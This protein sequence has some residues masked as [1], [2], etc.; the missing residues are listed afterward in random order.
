[1]HIVLLTNEYP[2]YVY[3]GAGVHLSHLAPALARAGEGR[4]TVEV[5]SFGDQD[6]A[7][8]MLTVQGVAAP[9]SIPASTPQHGKLFDTLGRNLVM[10]GRVGRAD[11]VHAHTWY[12]HFGGVLV[13]QLTGARLVL[14][15]HSLEPHRPW[16]VEQLGTAYNASTWIERHT[17]ASADGVIAVAEAMKRDVLA[18]YD[19]DPARVAVIPNGV[20]PEEFRP[21]PDPDRARAL[22]VDPSVPS[23]LF[24]GRVTRQKGLA[25]LLR[26]VPHLP[27]GTQVIVAA[28]QA[29]TPE[30]ASEAAALV[31]ASEAA[32]HHVV[33]IEGMLPR[34]DLAVLYSHASVFC[35]PSVYEP[36]G[37]INLEAM[38]CARPVVAAAVGGVPEVVVDGE[39]GLLVPLDPISDTNP[40]PSNPDAFARDLAEAITRVLARPDEARR[41]GQ[42]GRTRVEEHFSWDIIARRTLAFYEKVRGQKPEVREEG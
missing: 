7:D 20:D 40:D 12:A 28:G 2:P 24:V 17:Y 38:A 41:M 22:G 32:G 34:K 25:H 10:A 30:L 26:A 6:L 8:G 11:V 27:E 19:V 42:A 5:L 29:D 16:K 37:I 9:A 13:Q 15:T 31:A 4:H 35:C 21:R 14:T 39:T 36:F 23:V 18:L 1:M 3:G 33:W